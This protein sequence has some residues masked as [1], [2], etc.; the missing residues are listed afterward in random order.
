M[1]KH[2]KLYAA[3]AALGLGLVVLPVSAQ[4]TTLTV[5]GTTITDIS[6]ATFA[7]DANGNT[8]ITVTAPVLD[9]AATD[10]GGSAGGD[11][12]G[13]TGGDTGG[14]TGGDTGGSTGGDT[15][16]STGG[17][18]GGST[19]GD[20][21]GS[22]GG[23]SSANCASSSTVACGEA[24]DALVAQREYN[25]LYPTAL[26]PAGSYAAGTTADNYRVTYRREFT[27]GSSSTAGG[28]F[29][30]QNESGVNFRYEITLAPGQAGALDPST[31]GSCAG[32]LFRGTGSVGWSIRNFSGYCHVS[33]NT[34]YFLDVTP[35]SYA[36]DFTRTLGTTVGVD[37][38]LREN[39][40][41]EQRRVLSK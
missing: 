6:S 8:T 33:P 12:G 36:R 22:T 14:S 4:T 41:T 19:G 7:V 10:D 5:N 23:G 32:N 16:G 39:M 11:T 25:V 20:T 29:S 17:D 38:F 1:G 9:V 40:Y 27:L 3:I 13:S 24:F 2:S 31:Q 15:G 26:I 30:W 18:T 28:Q 21:G 37:T 35:I 34:T